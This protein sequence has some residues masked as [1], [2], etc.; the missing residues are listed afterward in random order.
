[1]AISFF[2]LTCGWAKAWAEAKTINIAAIVAVKLRFMVP[3]DTCL[4]VLSA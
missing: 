4:C 2:S 1:M 3:P